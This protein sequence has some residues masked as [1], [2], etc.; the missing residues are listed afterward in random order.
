MLGNDTFP[1]EARQSSGIIDHDGTK[2]SEQC[3]KQ[4]LKQGILFFGRRN[5]AI[6]PA[7]ARWHGSGTTV[8]QKS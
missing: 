3:K 7:A 5:I 1:V 6:V 2:W 8:E 4:A